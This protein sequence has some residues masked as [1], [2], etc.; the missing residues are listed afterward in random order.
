M[1]IKGA[2]EERTM[3]RKQKNRDVMAGRMIRSKKGVI[4]TWFD[5]VIAICGGAIFFFII[6]FFISS[7]T[8]V[9]EREIRAKSET[10]TAEGMLTAYLSSMIDDDF[11]YPQGTRWDVLSQTSG[12]SKEGMTFAGLIIRVGENTSNMAY[13]DMLRMQ[14]SGLLDNMLGSEKWRLEIEYPNSVILQY[15]NV[16]GDIR[17]AEAKLPSRGYLTT[18]VRLI[19]KES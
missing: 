15:G 12:L 5:Y 17:V 3:G 6:F 4:N 18:K 11:S 14:T 16:K 2:H 9:V 13:K 19:T 8:A 1:H 10:I 7:G